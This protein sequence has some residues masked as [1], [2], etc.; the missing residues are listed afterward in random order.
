MKNIFRVCQ[1]AGRIVKKTLRVRGVL[2][3]SLRMRQKI[4][5]I[6]DISVLKVSEKLNVIERNIERQVL[7]WL[8]V[9]IKVEN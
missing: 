5:I 1:T 7:Y 8:P 2:L 4:L 6:S 9:K 3:N